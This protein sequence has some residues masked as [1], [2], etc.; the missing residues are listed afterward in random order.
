M[1]LRVVKTMRPSR[2][3]P[4]R[5]GPFIRGNSQAVRR[6][7]LNLK[8]DGPNPSSRASTT[9]TPAEKLP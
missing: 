9:W 2:E 1:A 4:G 3:D 6:Q 5:S 8:T 7:A